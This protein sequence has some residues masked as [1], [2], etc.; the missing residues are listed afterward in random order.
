MTDLRKQDA[1]HAQEQN[2]ELVR[3]SKKREQAH[4]RTA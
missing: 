3:E 2:N 4:G 1:A